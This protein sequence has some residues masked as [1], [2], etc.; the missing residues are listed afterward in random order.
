M[1]CTE[2]GFMK[3]SI[4]LVTFLE[5]LQETAVN[6]FGISNVDPKTYVDLSLRFTL[7]ETEE[8]FDEL[9]RT[10]H[11]SVQ[12]DALHGFIEKYFDGADEDMVRCEAEDY[13]EEPEGFLSKVE[14]P[15]VR[16]WALKVHSLWKTLSRRVSS[17]VKSTPHLHTLLPLPA[18]F[19]IPGARYREVYY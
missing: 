5:R 17:G 12:A 4:P 13:V 2:I 15:E 8:A 1:S 9:P 18:P 6:T 7:S 14:H 11:G 3:P 19:I 10:S 16:A